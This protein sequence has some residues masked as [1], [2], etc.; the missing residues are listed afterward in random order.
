MIP[1]STQ[2]FKNSGLYRELRDIRQHGCFLEWNGQR[3]LNL[4]SND[5]LGLSTRTDWQREWLES[6]AGGEDYLNGSLSSRLL[7]GN[8]PVFSELEACLA[9]LYGREA[10]LVF[11]SGYHANL[12][13]LPAL[14]GRRDLILADKLVHASIIDGLRLCECKWMRYRHNDCDDLVRLLERHRRDYE[15][16]FI[17]TESVFSM[18]G[19]RADLARLVDIKNRYDALLYLDEAHGVGVFGDRGLGLA[20]EQQCLHDIE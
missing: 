14:S 6:M 13:I 16:V 8:A 15:R 7:T 1:F 4:S 10:C 20:E 3:Y 2:E 11:N 12:G 5:Y 19:D 17:V 18:D 9:G